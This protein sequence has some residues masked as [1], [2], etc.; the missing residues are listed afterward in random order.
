[1]VAA[2][3][4]ADEGIGVVRVYCANDSDEIEIETFV[5]WDAGTPYAEVDIDKIGDVLILRKGSD[6]SSEYF[7]IGDNNP[8]TQEC[9]HSGRRVRVTL[10]Q[11]RVTVFEPG[12]LVN[13]IRLPQ[14][15]VGNVRYLLRSPLSNK[16][17]ECVGNHA[18][19]T[20]GFLCRPFDPKSPMDLYKTD[21]G[22]H[23]PP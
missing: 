19:S 5:T 23:L 18:I 13:E 10:D 2:H 16:W 9:G 11:G 1:M 4:F 7:L 20:R 17:E 3:A 12:R 6:G 21:D 8:V 14:M 15:W 22:R